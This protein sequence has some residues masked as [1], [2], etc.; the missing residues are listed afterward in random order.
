MKMKKSHQTGNDRSN[1]LVEN[2]EK[3][4]NN[5]LDIEN[6]RNNIYVNC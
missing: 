2:K 6:S 4:I 1:Y 3:N 5:Q